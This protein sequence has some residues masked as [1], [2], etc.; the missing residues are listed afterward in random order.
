MMPILEV[1]PVSSRLEETETPP[2]KVQ[3]PDTV[4]ACE[5]DAGPPAP[6][7]RERDAVVPEMG[8]SK[9]AVL[10]EREPMLVNTPVYPS[11]TSMVL[12]PPEP[13]S[14]PQEN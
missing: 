2:E 9:C 5:R 10:K 3:R 11:R 14:S 6:Q 13:A 8:R 1:A 4:S 12:E 7:S